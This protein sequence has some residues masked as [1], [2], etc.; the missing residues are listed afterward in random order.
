MNAADLL[1]LG[2]GPVA[3][4]GVQLSA[5]KIVGHIIVDGVVIN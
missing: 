4:M 1:K 3:M 5:G 2:L